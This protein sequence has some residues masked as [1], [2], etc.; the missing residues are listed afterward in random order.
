MNQNLMENIIGS[1]IYQVYPIIDNRI[2][3]IIED[4]PMEIA[5]DIY[6]M[7]SYP[8]NMF[9][10]MSRMN[11]VQETDVLYL[12][13]DYV[14]VHQLN[15]NEKLQIDIYFHVSFWALP[16]DMDSFGVIL[17]NCQ[18]IANYGL[19]K[20]NQ[21]II[22]SIKRDVMAVDD[23]ITFIPLI[24]ESEFV[25][26]G[27]PGPP[28]ENIKVNMEDILSPDLRALRVRIIFDVIYEEYYK[29]KG[30][31]YQKAIDHFYSQK[32]Q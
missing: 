11:F 32:K 1:L 5:Q 21:N 18:S 28:M 2:R 13:G 22:S 19:E 26:G 31:F 3:L 10:F 4:D 23:N 29:I 6:Y 20:I 9:L 25:N 17:Y 27:L 7:G 14:L 24:V 15:N 12:G 16:D 30:K 8:N